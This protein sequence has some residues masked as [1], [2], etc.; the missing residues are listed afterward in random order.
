MTGVPV[1]GDFLR[2]A[3]RQLR[4]PAGWTQTAAHG[5]DLAEVTS[6]LLRFITV[7]GRYARD[8]ITAFDEVPDHDRRRPPD[9]G[10]PRAAADVLAALSAALSALAPDGPAAQPPAR[11]PAC[12]LARR[13]D[14]ATTSLAA[15]RDLLQAHFARGGKVRVRRSGWA[16]VIA[17]PAAAEALL[18]DVAELAGQAAELAGGIPKAHGRSDSADTAALRLEAACRW[19]AHADGL[20]QAAR[21]RQP[22]RAADRELLYAIPATALPARRVPAGGQPVPELCEAIITTAERTRRAAWVAARLDRLSPAISVTSWRRIAASGTAASSHCQ[23]LLAALAARAA[24][25]DDTETSSR[26]QAAAEGAGYTVRAWVRSSRHLDQVTTDVR[27]P[28]TRATA[29]AGD[30]AQLTGRLADAILGAG[31]SGA[32]GAGGPGAAAR[33]GGLALVPGDIPQVL[34]AVHHAVDGLAR[35]AEANHEQA[36][37]A[38]TARRIFVPTRAPAAGAAPGEAYVPASGER[39][40][41]F[42]LATSGA[43]TTSDRTAQAAGDLAVAARAPSRVLAAARAATRTP[44]RTRR[45]RARPETH[46]ATPAGPAAPAARPDDRPAEAGESRDLTGPFEARMR[47]IGV[48]SPRFL[49]RASALDRD[50]RE[51]ITEAATERLTQR[52][53][54]A[55][56]VAVLDAGRPPSRRVAHLTPPGRSPEQELEAEP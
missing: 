12:E 39:T 2:A 15:G 6:S 42:L 38:V 51:I 3:H 45:V 50:G 25:H 10:W 9:T 26:L 1:L 22:V 14:A 32:G 18:A 49:R 55:G 13:L 16:P 54:A 36:R 43:W 23:L 35:L 31:T 21:R 30:L 34:A 48:T 5:R 19:L 47:E 41:T 11:P 40:L 8:V 33:A 17:S 44:R 27:G 28:V 56:P 46:Q 37:A 20:V 52:V 29:E 53:P 4:R 7:T 24:E